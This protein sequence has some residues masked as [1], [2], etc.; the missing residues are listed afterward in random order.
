VVAS[1]LPRRG[2]GIRPAPLRVGSTA[3]DVPGEAAK[4]GGVPEEL[5]DSA[6]LA[7]V[8]L[9]EAGGTA[10]V[11]IGTIVATIAFLRQVG[12]RV[13]PRQRFR[14]YRASLGRSIL[15]GLELL[16]AAD[17]VSTVTVELSLDSLAALGLLVLIRTFLS[18]ALET[19]IE[20]HW[21][22]KREPARGGEPAERAK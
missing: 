11:L 7:I 9:L 1:V 4:E 14:E 13:D 3:P 21:P 16:V 17:I 12:A 20:G 18:F 19:E 22:W 6:M 5:F 15:L 2:A 10:V 8:R